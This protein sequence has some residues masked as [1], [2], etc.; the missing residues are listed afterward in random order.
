V[1][2]SVVI[3]GATLLEAGLDGAIAT[4]AGTDAAEAGHPVDPCEG[5]VCRKGQHCVRPTG[6]CVNPSCVGLPSTCGLSKNR[7]C[8][9]STVVA[10]GTYDRSNDP[11]SPATVT[12][13]RLDT[14]EITVGRFRKFVAAYAPDRMIAGAG[15]DPNDPKDTGWDPAWSSELPATREE[16]ESD[17]SWCDSRFTAWTHLPSGN[18]NRPMNCIDWYEAFAFCI[19]DGGR[20]PTEAEWNYAAAGGNEQREYPWGDTTPGDD[21]NLAVYG[22]YYSGTGTCTSIS[23]TAAVGS[24]PKGNGRWG[25][26]DLAG[27][28]WEWVRDWYGDYPLPCSNCIAE[29]P[30][31]NRVA[32]GGSFYDP[33]IYLSTTMRGNFSEPNLQTFDIGARCARAP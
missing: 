14:Y 15:K 21:A 8:C 13:F 33:M 24:A 1:D 32:R 28:V 7:S 31:A 25:Q 19:W 9:A 20:L 5:V 23:N 27:S 3:D 17:V 26:A 11:D 6:E 22:C 12:T 4:E 16:L 2:A 29:T 30:G 10:G 18:E